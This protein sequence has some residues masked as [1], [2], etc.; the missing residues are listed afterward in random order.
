MGTRPSFWLIV[1]Q[2]ESWRAPERARED[3]YLVGAINGVYLATRSQ[4][5]I[6]NRKQISWL[7]AWFEERPHFSVDVFVVVEDFFR[8]AKKR[9]EVSFNRDSFLLARRTDGRT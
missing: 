1:E 4:F 6:L 5:V 2:G 8:W 9:K 3:T 7:A